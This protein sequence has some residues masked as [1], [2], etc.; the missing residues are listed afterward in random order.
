MQTHW[1]E[2]VENIPKNKPVLFA[3]THSNSFLDALY[4][5]S[6]FNRF[7]YCLARGDV[8]R[9]PI[10][11]KILRSLCVLPIYRQSEREPD[12]EIKNDQTFEECQAL[13]R[14]NSWVLIFPEG[15]SAH[16]TEVLPLKKGAS[17]MAQ[18]AWAAG[19]DVQVIPV[20]ITYDSFTHW[21]KKC[22][23]IFS[24]P[25]QKTDIQF[26][27]EVKQTLQINEKLYASLNNNFPS[28]FQ[29]DTKQTLWGW[30]GRGL[31]YAGWVV[32]FPLYFFCQ[33]WGKRFA[34]KSVFYDSIAIGLLSILL[35]FYYLLLWLMFHFI[36]PLF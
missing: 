26:D 31:Y 17:V 29:F 24:K 7:V 20:S 9:K 3:V 15:Y 10:F 25:I 35:P 32:H 13:F 18:R 2:G 21:G 14:E 1:L 34:K 4:I 12:A 19:I 8:F 30:F 23:I 6:S 36:V 22:D 5:A 28:P 16:Q 27:T 11:N 33:Y